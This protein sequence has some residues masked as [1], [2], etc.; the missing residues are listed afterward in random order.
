MAADQFPRLA[1]ALCADTREDA[2]SGKWS[3]ARVKMEKKGEMAA[4]ASSCPWF[5]VPLVLFCESILVAVHICYPCCG[6]RWMGVLV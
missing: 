1:C 6:R 5:V 4:S 2:I 3:A